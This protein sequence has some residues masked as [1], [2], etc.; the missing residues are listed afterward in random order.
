MARNALDGPSIAAVGRERER[1]WINTVGWVE[2]KCGR[3]LE[4]VI[5]MDVVVN[6]KRLGRPMSLIIPREYFF[7]K[8][9]C[10]RLN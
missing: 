3:I 2:G 5:L 6:K 8:V 4:S 7:F 1:E 10:V 9:D